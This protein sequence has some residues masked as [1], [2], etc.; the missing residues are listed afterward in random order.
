MLK[1]ANTLMIHQNDSWEKGR[2]A[3]YAGCLVPVPVTASA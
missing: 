2:H 1:T 3:I